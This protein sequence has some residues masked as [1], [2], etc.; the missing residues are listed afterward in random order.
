MPHKVPLLFTE[1]LPPK[2]S[3][4]ATGSLYVFCVLQ[5]ELEVWVKMG[6]NTNGILAAD[7]SRLKEDTE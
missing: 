6:E 1:H 2:M 7:I 3:V 5:V 4:H